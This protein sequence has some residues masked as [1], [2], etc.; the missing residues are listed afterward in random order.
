MTGEPHAATL[1][2]TLND[3]L[4]GGKFNGSDGSDQ[5]IGTFS[6]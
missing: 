5:V 4:K 6:C 3:D 2:G 1:S